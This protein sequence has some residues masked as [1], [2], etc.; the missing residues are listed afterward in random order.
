M[1]PSSALPCTY[2]TTSARSKIL[3]KQDSVPFH[4]WQGCKAEENKEMGLGG[5][6]SATGLNET[7]QII[8][9][10]ELKGTLTSHLVQLP[11]N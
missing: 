2:F 8:E 7:P 11:C 3:E 10:F 4:P 5:K 1:G 6:K 9:S